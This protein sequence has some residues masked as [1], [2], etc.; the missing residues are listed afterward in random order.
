MFEARQREVNS[1]RKQDAPRS[2]LE[3][4]TRSD[5]EYRS[6]L[7]ILIYPRR[8]WTSHNTQ[9]GSLD[10]CDFDF[11]GIS[12]PGS[13][14]EWDTSKWHTQVALSDFEPEC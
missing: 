8:H 12:G 5:Q 14:Q 11:K 6:P 7:R 13:V 10:H 2:H 3:F 9:N 1:F 4:Q